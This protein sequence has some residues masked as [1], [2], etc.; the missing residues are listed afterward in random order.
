LD[1]VKANKIF[2]RLALPIPT[3]WPTV[4]ANARTAETAK[5]LGVPAAVSQ[6][7][8]LRLLKGWEVTDMGVTC[9]GGDQ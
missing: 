9:K 8:K 3:A 4:F 5:T 7:Y 6:A 2:L 1:E